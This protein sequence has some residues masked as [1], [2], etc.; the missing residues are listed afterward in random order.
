[1]PLADIKIGRQ[2]GVG[3]TK[4]VFEAEW[5]GRT[6]K[7]A[8]LRVRQAN[9]GN[10]P[11]AL[12]RE[13]AALSQLGAHPHIV[14]LLG[15]A[16]A[17]NGEVVALVQLAPLG[18][19]DVLLSG[20]EP[21]GAADASAVLM[22]ACAGVHHMA[23]CSFVH[24]DVSLRN[25]LAFRLAPGDV[26]VKLADLTGALRIKGA[27]T[28]DGNGRHSSCGGTVYAPKATV[29]VRWAP[30]EVRAA[31]RRL[32]ALM[33]CTVSHRVASRAP[34]LIASHLMHTR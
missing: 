2:I 30:P 32:R 29:A 9:P 3:S 7:V 11:S 21:I 16:D 34:H 4:S 28:D 17:P 19:L 26:H 8:V 25:V 24:T 5:K 20:R 13:V 23:G 10:R 31:T 1:V 12:P 22:Q 33:V 6:E 27:R 15:V 14:S 18:S